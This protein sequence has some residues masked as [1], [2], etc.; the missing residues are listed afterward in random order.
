[1]NARLR[2]L[3]RIGRCGP[4][5]RFL[6]LVAAR[7]RVPGHELIAFGLLGKPK[8]GEVEV[9]VTRDGVRYALDLRDDAHRLMFLN[10]FERP[11]RQH[12]LGLLPRGGCVVDVGAN[13]GFWTIPAAVRLGLG[14]R[15]IAFEPNPWALAKLRNN[16]QLNEGYIQA[17]ISIFASAVG[18]EAAHA[19]LCAPDLEAYASQASLH[20]TT[21]GREGNSRV[22]VPVIPL[23]SVVDGPVD[24]LK[25]DV[26]G[27]EMSVLAGA[28]RLFSRSPPFYVAIE[29]HGG[30]LARA[31]HTPEE[32]I[33]CLKQ[34]GYKAV[35]SDGTFATTGVLARCGGVPYE[36]V[37][38]RS[39]SC[40]G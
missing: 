26:E 1:M 2:E 16:I 18:R 33:S 35:Y 36:T 4:V 19:L 27:H 3:L 22:E 39:D 24:L 17:E 28:E 38:W 10:L 12:V 14:G 31:G 23:D 21:G 40:S 11:L 6:S 34:L 25:I 32:L 8:R 20:P 5:A 37:L 29:I 13:V 15:V 30:C 9:E 7:V